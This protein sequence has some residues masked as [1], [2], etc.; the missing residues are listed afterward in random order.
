MN[1]EIIKGKWKEIKG[2]IQKSWGNITDDEVEKT[3]G[4]MKAIAGLL[5]QKYGMAKEEAAA[6]IA[7]L[8][9]KFEQTSE[10]LKKK[11]AEKVE[12]IKGHIKN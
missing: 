7:G 9:D 2:E 3:K 12:Q 11:T 4:D 6:K 8:Y 10:S 5:E 1:Q